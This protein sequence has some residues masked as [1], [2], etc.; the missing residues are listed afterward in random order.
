MPVPV[1][2]IFESPKEVEAV[3]LAILPVVPLAFA[4]PEG[5]VGPVGPV[6]PAGPVPPE[7]PEDPDPPLPPGGP[8]GPGG[9]APPLAPL[10]P[11][12]PLDP[13]PP[14]VPGGPGGPAPPAAPL[15]PD[16]PDEPELAAFTFVLISPLDS[17]TKTLVLV[18]V[19]SDDNLIVPLT[20]NLYKG[21]ATPIPTLPVMLTP[22]LKTPPTAVKFPANVSFPDIS[23]CHRLADALQPPIRNTLSGSRPI[24]TA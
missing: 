20:S 22:P 2:V 14:V 17:I 23:N 8:G 7:V 6:G 18:P 13:T 21:V 19:V 1:T 15:V 16:E 24:L 11:D 12:E 9:P 3:N 10:V 4:E 5:P